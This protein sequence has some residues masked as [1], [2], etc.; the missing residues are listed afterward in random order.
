[1]KGKSVNCDELMDR[2]IDLRAGW[3]NRP[4]LIGLSICRKSGFWHPVKACLFKMCIKTED[5]LYAF[6]FHYFERD[7]ISQ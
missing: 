5:L 2:K 3:K 7:T 4:S 6:S 1:M